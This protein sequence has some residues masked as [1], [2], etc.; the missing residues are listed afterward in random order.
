MAHFARYLCKQLPFFI[1]GHLHSSYSDVLEQE[2]DDPM[3]TENLN[4]IIDR[5]NSICALSNKGL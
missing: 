5:L 4:R 1:L 2:S 3:F